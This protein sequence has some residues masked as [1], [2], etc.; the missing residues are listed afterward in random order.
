MKLCD[1]ICKTPIHEITPLNNKDNRIYFKRD[2]LQPFS[3]GGN[4]VRIAHKI[5]EYMLND[6]CNVLITYG[7]KFS[8]LCR[9][10]TNLCC[11]LGVECYMISVSD[12]DHG[13]ERAFN[14][15][16]T[17]L[18]GAKVIRCKKAEVDQVVDELKARLAAEGKKCHYV[19]DRESET[20]QCSAYAGVYDEIYRQQLESGVWFDYIF[21]ASGA[22]TTQG[23]LIIGKLIHPQYKAP[24]SPDPKIVGISTA[25]LYERGV[26]KLK[27]HVSSYYELFRNGDTPNESDVDRE[28]NLCCDYLCGGY[29]LYDGEIV[30]T[31]NR[32]LSIN[33]IELDPTYTGKAYLGMEKYL[34]E[35]GIKGKNVLFIHTGGAPLF[36]DHLLNNT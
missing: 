11:S 12:D 1:V 7:N 34:S 26:F 36:F 8:N 18:F 31:C 2:D 17:E 19:H 10:T 16:M 5:V 25:R 6:G 4:K 27:E 24:S 29:G 21:S 30:D 28:L 22:G 15:T 32:M 20:V 23:G 35:N 3:F 33:G 13:C 14:G 9:V